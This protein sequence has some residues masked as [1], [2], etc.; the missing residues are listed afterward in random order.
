MEAQFASHGCLPDYFPWP[1]KMDAGMVAGAMIYLSG[2]KSSALT[3]IT[4]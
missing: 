4:N 1:Q 2:S 3:A